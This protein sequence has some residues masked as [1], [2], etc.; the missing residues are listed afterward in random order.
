MRVSI[1]AMEAATA[2]RPQSVAGPKIGGPAMKQPTFNWETEDKYS[3]LETFRLE[4]NNILS[5]Y[6]TPQ[7]EQL[8]IVNNCIERKGLQFLEMLANEEKIMCST[9][10]GLF[11][12]LAS[13]FRPQFNETIQSLQFCKLSR[14]G[15]E[16]Q[17]SR[18]GG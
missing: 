4:V 7:T 9:L 16:I 3:K 18:W 15:E 2:E 6:Y 5:T 10:E 1:Q 8:V 11:E 13:K 14:K 12:T 17:K